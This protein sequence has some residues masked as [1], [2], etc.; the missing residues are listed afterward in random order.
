MTKLEVLD[1]ILA[2]LADEFE[3]GNRRFR[4]FTPSSPAEFEPLRECLATLIA[5]GSLIDYLK[6]K[7]Y[8]LT[9]GGYLKYKGR[10]DLLRALGR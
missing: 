6:T 4:T 9:G 5:E 7:S 3:S 1:E 2:T 10:I 8:Q